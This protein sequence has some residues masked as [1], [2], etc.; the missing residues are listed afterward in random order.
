MSCG[1][2]ARAIYVHAEVQVRVPRAAAAWGK[3]KRFRGGCDWSLAKAP[4]CMH[5]QEP[6]AS[7]FVIVCFFSSTE[8]GIAGFVK[9]NAWDCAGKQLVHMSRSL[10]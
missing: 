10:A 7:V 8:V 6:A 3:G 1:V 4:Y 5:S 9:T 2:G